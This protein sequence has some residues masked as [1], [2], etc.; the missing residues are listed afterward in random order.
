[1]ITLVS[2]HVSHSIRDL[3]VITPLHSSLLPLNYE[4]A[5]AYLHSFA[6]Q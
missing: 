5:P 3:K 4:L 6:A 2:I 1:M